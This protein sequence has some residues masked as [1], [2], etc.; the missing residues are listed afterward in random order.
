MEQND[1]PGRELQRPSEA[2]IGSGHRFQRVNTAVAIFERRPERVPQQ[3]G[4]VLEYSASISGS[5]SCDRQ[6]RR[7]SRSASGSRVHSSPGTGKVQE[8]I[9]GLPA[10]TL[11]LVGSPLCPS[12]LRL[13]LWGF[14]TRS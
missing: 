1:F 12:D 4:E 9:G 8:V 5:R 7:I 10:S 14:E 13:H 3:A 2:D 6:G 11:G